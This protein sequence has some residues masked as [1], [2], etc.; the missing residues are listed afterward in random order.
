MIG[1]KIMKKIHLL[2]FTLILA[3]LTSCAS[4]I[5]PVQ[6]IDNNT[7]QQ[8]AAKKE[9]KYSNFKSDLFM[10]QS[11]ARNW[12]FSAELVKAESRWVNENGSSNWTFYFKSPFKNKALK[13]DMGFGNEIP[14][15]F[16]GRE[17]R[18]FDIRVD[19]DKAIE[20]AKKQGLKKFPISEMTL[21]KRSVYAEWEIRSSSGTYR[22]N[23]ER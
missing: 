5:N 13:V 8:S 23:A 16:F 21:E 18:E 3:S 7:A 9:E 1:I 17:I 4:E 12:D 11:R 15:M 22:I 14:D 10:A 20:E 2:G 6:V 19:V